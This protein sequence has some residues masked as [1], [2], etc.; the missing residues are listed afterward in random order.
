MEPEACYRALRGLV[1]KIHRID[2]ID[3]I[4]GVVSGAVKHTTSSHTNR[5]KPWLSS[6]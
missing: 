2:I 5:L 6:G 4:V 3:M 1:P